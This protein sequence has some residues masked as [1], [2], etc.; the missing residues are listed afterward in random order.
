MRLITVLALV[1]AFTMGCV[2]SKTC[3][4]P[5]MLVYGDCCLDENGDGICDRDK[6]VCG[7][8]YLLVGRE[9]CLDVNGNGLC[10]AHEPVST[11]STSTQSTSTTERTT[12]TTLFYR[13]KPTTTTNP[14]AECADISDCTSTI[15]VT[16][17][18]MGREVHVHYTPVRCS[19]NRCVYR[20]SME[21]SAYPCGSWQRCVDGMGCVTEKSITTTTI[22]VFYTYEYGRILD[23][24]ADRAGSPMST[25][26][27]TLKMCFDGDGGIRYD[28]RSGNVTGYHAYSK[29]DFAGASEYCIDIRNLMEYYCESGTLRS[30]RHECPSSCSNGR[31]CGGESFA[32]A[33][34]RDCCSGVCRTA[35]LTKYCM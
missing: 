20:S 14:E 3:E 2:G 35:G 23:R 34:D 13:P 30:V 1:A 31:C 21:I 15:D 29:T 10:D 27:T 11:T 8:N 4:K 24:V 22:E 6:P 7:E 28:L 19:K 18:D 9:C 33:G 12:T 5:Y 17:D 26:T 16:C 32:C 25:T